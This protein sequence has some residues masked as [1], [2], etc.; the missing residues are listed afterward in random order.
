LLNRS[1]QAV[2]LVSGSATFASGPGALAL[3]VPIDRVKPILREVMAV[4]RLAPAPSLMTP[5]VSER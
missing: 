2:G 5:P 1:G 4:P 3:A